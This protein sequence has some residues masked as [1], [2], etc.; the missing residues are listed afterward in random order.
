MF[1][2]EDVVNH[3]KCYF[4]FLCLFIGAARLAFTHHNIMW[5]SLC[6]IMKAGLLFN[7]TCSKWSPDNGFR[8]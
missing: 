6:Y 3:N 7:Q 1:M 2:T 4:S 5:H 8:N